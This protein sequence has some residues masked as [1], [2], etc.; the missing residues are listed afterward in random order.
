MHTIALIAE[1][2]IHRRE[3]WMVYVAVLGFGLGT[4][5]PLNAQSLTWLGRHPH[6]PSH[7]TA[8]LDVSADGT[9]VVGTTLDDPLSRRAFRW[10]PEEGMQDLG[11]LRPGGSSEAH[12]VSA[13]GT[14]VVGFSLGT[15]GTTMRAIRWV[16]GEMQ[17]LSSGWAYD[18]SA[19]GT[20]VVGSSGGRAFRWE[21]GLFQDLGTLGG[22]RSVALG[23]SLDGM[24]AVGVALNASGV[25]RAFRWTLEEG[26]QDLGTLGGDRS[27]AYSVSADGRV[28]VGYSENANRQ[29][30]AFRWENGVMQ[31]L[32]ALGGDMSMAYGV[33]GD[34]TIVV[35]MVVY[36]GSQQG[37][38]RWTPAG[39][40]EDLN[41]AYASLLTNGSHLAAA[42]AIS[43]DGRYIVGCGYNASR[44]RAEAFLLDTWRTGD[45]NGDGCID[46]GDLLNVLFAF[47][48]PG[49]GYTRHEDINKDGTVDEADL[50]EVLTNFGSGC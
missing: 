20:V 4:L 38:F 43:F 40:M 48:S 13:D 22:N 34:G 9:V 17:D 44:R 5:V 46:E 36:S 21:N 29:W 49:T 10:T 47:G 6:L 27:D 41:Q 15:T 32:G 23:V 24:V 18:V 2:I 33:S 35:G 39:G 7:T 16:S 3:S 12:G 45:T 19:D 1:C 26:M 11:M 8:A 28:V 42:F 50:L 31:D 14:V 25:P 30:R 37:A